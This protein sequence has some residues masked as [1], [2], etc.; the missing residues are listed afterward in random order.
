M[1]IS[2][3]VILLDQLSKTAVVYYFQRGESTPVLGNF[4][5]LTY[6]LN[7]GGVFGSKLGS[8]NFYTIISVLALMVTSWF[9]F[10]TK[11]R[12]TCLRV[13]LCM[14]LG[15]A[16]GNLIDRLRFGE[17][18]DFLDFDFFNIS[19]LPSKVL[20]FN[21]PGFHLDRWPVFNLADSFVLIGVVFVMVH[22]LK[23]S[24]STSQKSEIQPN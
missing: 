24:K 1:I 21:F 16:V 4:F 3:L 22:L 17:V 9:F 5:R 14:V 12:E 8:Q 6:I 2:L 7:P 13:G 10:K 19:L 15:G 23:S 18:V 20:F 11:S